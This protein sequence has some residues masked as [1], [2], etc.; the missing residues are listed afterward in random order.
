MDATLIQS[1]ARPVK[2]WEAVEGSEPAAY[3]IPEKPELSKDPD[4]TWTKK[5][6]KSYFGYKGF[7]ITDAEDGFV[8][9]GHVTPA[10]KAEVK[11]LEPFLEKASISGRLYVDKGYA[12]SANQG[13]LEENNIKSGIMGKPLTAAQKRFNRLIS[14][15]R[16]KIEQ[17]F[18][19]L[20]RRFQ[21]IRC[22]GACPNDL[23]SHGLQSAQRAQQDQPHTLSTGQL[24]P[25]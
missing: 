2:T 4:A 12:S 9:H 23:Q 11:E 3:A 14:K 16:Y 13:L 6:S 20:K 10:N 1:A 17:G 18:G 19:T 24:R 8:T 22:K 5:G 7:M 21:F 25:V 15:I